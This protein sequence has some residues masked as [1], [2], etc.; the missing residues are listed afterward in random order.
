[1]VFSILFYFNQHIILYLNILFVV[2]YIGCNNIY[3][4]HNCR[5]VV[6]ILWYF[7]FGAY[8]YFN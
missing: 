8:K 2:G 6:N 3:F 1:M 7:N 4:F 5:G